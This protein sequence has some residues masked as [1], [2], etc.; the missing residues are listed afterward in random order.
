MARSLP[1]AG[2]W[3]KTMSGSCCA[4]RISG[5]SRLFLERTGHHGLTPTQF[6]AL[7]KA[8]ELGRVTQNLLGRL[9]AMDPATVQGVVRRLIR[10]RAAAAR[11][12]DPM[13][14]RTAVLAPT[15]AGIALIDRSVACAQRSHDATL[16]PLSLPNRPS[17]WPCCAS[18]PEPD[19]DPR[20]MPSTAA[21]PPLGF[22]FSFA[23]LADRDGL[24]RLDRAFLK[25]GGRGRQA[26]TPGCWQRGPPR[27]RWRRRPKASWWWRSGRIWMV[28][29]PRC[30]AS[31]RKPWRWRARPHAL[32]PIHACKRLFVQRQAVKKYPHP[33]AFD[34]RRPA[35]G[36]GSAHGRAA[37]R[38]RFRDAR[39][40]LGEG[41]RRRGA[42]SGAALCGLGDA[43]A[44]GP[45]GAQGRHAVPRAAPARLQ[46]PG[47]G[48]DHRARRRHHAAPA[49]A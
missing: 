14:R 48:G 44:A 45:G 49:G 28:S 8:V 29:S 33:A 32:D 16:A 6:T 27:T 23:D 5:M 46:P 1:A 18:W 38:A 7:F 43:D 31:R 47:P 12:K 41:G 39:R 15:E 10:P 24:V 40:G 26:C 30:S 34:G 2:F 13:D 17:F 37:D 42:R 4:A 25:P 11:T 3:S 36:A 20:W 21:P 9:T 22:G 19:G 35:R